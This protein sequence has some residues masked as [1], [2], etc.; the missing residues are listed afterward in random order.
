M[1]LARESDEPGGAL[2]DAF[3][4]L[5]KWRRGLRREGE[6]GGPVGRRRRRCSSTIWRPSP[7]TTEKGV[8]CAFL[9]VHR[10]CDGHSSCSC[11][12]GIRCALCAEDRRDPA[13]L[14]GC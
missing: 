8:R 9:L 4:D 13:V 5:Q 1:A 11:C 12:I 7:A 10:Q 2:D 14:G 3:A 6:G